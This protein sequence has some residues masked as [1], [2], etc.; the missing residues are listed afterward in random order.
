MF[1]QLLISLDTFTYVFTCIYTFILKWKIYLQY[2][3]LQ[4][5]Y[6]QWHGYVLT[7]KEV[8]SIYKISFLRGGDGFAYHTK[9]ILK[10]K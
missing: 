3:C 7:K 10:E 8:L 1:T 4:W 5:E 9:R 2:L 6:L